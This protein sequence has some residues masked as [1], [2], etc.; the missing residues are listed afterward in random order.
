MC[1]ISHPALDFPNTSSSVSGLSFPH[2]QSP[3][4]LPVHLQLATGRRPPPHRY[5]LHRKPRAG[6][7]MSPP[8]MTLLLRRHPLFCHVPCDL[9]PMTW[10]NSVQVSEALKFSFHDTWWFWQM[11]TQWLW[12]CDLLVSRSIYLLV[13]NILIYLGFLCFAC[14]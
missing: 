5:Q 1:S 8:A 9:T 4:W 3:D 14:K 7:E 2:R 10:S 12:V 11:I 6:E 13:Q